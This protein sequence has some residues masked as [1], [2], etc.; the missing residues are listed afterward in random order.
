MIDRSLHEAVCYKDSRSLRVLISDHMP[1]TLSDFDHFHAFS[2]TGNPYRGTT[3][4]T[5]H[6]GTDKNILRG[7]DD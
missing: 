4:R 6:I 5:G 7:G 2:A 3:L 1:I